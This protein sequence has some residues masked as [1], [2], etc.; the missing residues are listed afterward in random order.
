V[1]PIHTG[2]QQLAAL[3]ALPL[4]LCSRCSIFMLLLLAGIHAGCVQAAETTQAWAAHLCDQVC[5]CLNRRVPTQLSRQLL[6]KVAHC[7]ATS[8]TWPAGGTGACSRDCKKQ[9]M[10][11]ACS[12]A[13]C[14]APTH[15]VM[16]QCVDCKRVHQCESK[17]LVHAT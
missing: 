2:L 13:R 8:I 17:R 5:N 7:R 16:R 14:W 3:S 12:L 6:S 9:G 15:H 10:C 4:S 11:I 1:P